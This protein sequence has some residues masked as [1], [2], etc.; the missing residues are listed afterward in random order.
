[1]RHGYAVNVFC[2]VAR[3]ATLTL[4]VGQ[5][6]RHGLN[7]LIHRDWRPRPTSA[8]LGGFRAASQEVSHEGIDM[9]FSEA[10]HCQATVPFA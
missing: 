5:H 7:C 3:H 1:M 9:R 10:L 2:H 4:S 8:T 6:H